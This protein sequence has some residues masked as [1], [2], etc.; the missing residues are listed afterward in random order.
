MCQASDAESSMPRN[1]N[2]VPFF[3]HT[4]AYRKHLS[5]TIASMH[6]VMQYKQK[7]NQKRNNRMGDNSNTF[8]DFSEEIKTLTSKLQS[9]S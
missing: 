6:D 7:Q 5:S 8:I 1:M 2:H 9:L 3:P 4:E